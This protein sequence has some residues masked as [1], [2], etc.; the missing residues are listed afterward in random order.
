MEQRKVTMKLGKKSSATRHVIFCIPHWHG[1][2]LNLQP[3]PQAQANAL[4]GV[5]Q[6]C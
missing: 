3:D 6:P 4:L 1:G 5:E 2:I